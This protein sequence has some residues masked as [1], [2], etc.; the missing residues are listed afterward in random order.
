MENFFW[1]V[2]LAFEPHLGY[3]RRAITKLGALITTIDDI[4]DVYGTLEE[5]KLFTYVVDR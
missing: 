2:G 4:Y 1:T 5:L 3:F